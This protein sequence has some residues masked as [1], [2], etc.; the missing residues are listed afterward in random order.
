MSDDREKNAAADPA[1]VAT[2]A[3][4]ERLERA[5]A[6]IDAAEFIAGDPVQFPRRYSRPEDIEVGYSVLRWRGEGARRSCLR[7][8]GCWGR[9]AIR[10]TDT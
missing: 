10:P 7:A 6:R 8:G 4:G 5:Y 2:P 1:A 3:L 9:W